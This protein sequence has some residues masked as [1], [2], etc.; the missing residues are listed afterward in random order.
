MVWTIARRQLLDYLIT[1]RFALVLAFSSAEPLGRYTR[2]WDGR[3][4][5]GRLVAPGLN[6]YRIEVQP[7]AGTVSRQ[8]VLR[9]VY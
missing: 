2:I 9:V 1:W 5:Q 3:D 6:L 7:D 8:G 4:D